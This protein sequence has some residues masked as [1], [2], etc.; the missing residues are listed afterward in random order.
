MLKLVTQHWVTRLNL[1]RGEDDNKIYLEN[2]CGED[3]R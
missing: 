3:S 1:R 2:K